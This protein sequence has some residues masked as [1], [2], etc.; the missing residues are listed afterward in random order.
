MAEYKT[1]STREPT[2]PIQGAHESQVE[3][4]ARLEI[5]SDEL[6]RFR[7]SADLASKMK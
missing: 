3:Y 7:C 1:E 2:F 6:E 5:Y 4:E